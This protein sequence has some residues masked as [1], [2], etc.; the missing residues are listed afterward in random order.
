M[1]NYYI[2]FCAEYLKHKFEVEMIILLWNNVL[3]IVIR[4]LE[5]A[6]NVKKFLL[7]EKSRTGYHSFAADV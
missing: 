2:Y 3:F 4:M 1:L 7:T 5:I 6:R